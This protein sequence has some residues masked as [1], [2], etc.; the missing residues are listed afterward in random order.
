MF[1]A[2]KAAFVPYMPEILG[3]VAMILALFALAILR[4]ILT[5]VTA[6]AKLRGVDLQSAEAQRLALA[7]K[8][9]AILAWGAHHGK[10]NTNA[11]VKEVMEYM[12]DTMGETLDKLK[13]DDTQLYQRSRAELEV[14]SQRLDIS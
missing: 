5:G 2:I 9:A 14:F 13:V 4:S 11:A 3:M 12:R 10:S 7:F 8:R 1:E 6:W